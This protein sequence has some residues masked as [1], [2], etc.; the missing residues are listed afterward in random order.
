MQTLEEAYGDEEMADQFRIRFGDDCRYLPWE[1]EAIWYCTCGTVNVSAEA[2]CRRC[3]RVRKALTRVNTAELRKETDRRRDREKHSEE[4][5]DGKKKIRISPWAVIPAAVIVMAAMAF[6]LFGSGKIFQRWEDATAAPTEKVEAAPE[7][8]TTPEPEATPSEAPVDPAEAEK[9]RAYERALQLLECADAGDASAL[10]QIGKTQ[11]DVKEG[12]TAAMLLYRAAL[13]AGPWRPCRQRG[14]RGAL[15][16]GHR[17]TGA[18][19][20]AAGL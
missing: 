9:N 6:L 5:T 3:R 7:A 16:R 13:E 11:E 8:A 4:E 15:P 17:R 12:E 2:R 20:P 10:S 19:S 18:D 1:G 14:L